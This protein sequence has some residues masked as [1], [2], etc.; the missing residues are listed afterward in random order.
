VATV[1][2][3]DVSSP[4]Y[5]GRFGRKIRHYASPFIA[6]STQAESAARAVLRTVS[7]PASEVRAVCAPNPALELGDTVEIDDGSLM[8]IESMSIGV[9][10]ASSMVLGLRA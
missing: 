9:E 1:E 3:L 2:D 7:R 8:I 5:V 4:T 6:S 10:A